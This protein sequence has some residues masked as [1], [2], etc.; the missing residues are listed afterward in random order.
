MNTD[1]P[2]DLTPEEKTILAIHL[3]RDPEVMQQVSGVLKPEDFDH[4]LE[5]G[6]RLIY[7]TAFE[8]WKKYGKP[9]ARPYLMSRI[10]EQVDDSVMFP[11]E[12]QKEEL[13]QFVDIIYRWPAGELA[14]DK[15][16]EL[17][18]KFVDER[19]LRRLAQADRPVPELIPKLLDA[20]SSSRIEGPADYTAHA[21]EQE[22]LRYII[23][24]AAR[25][26]GDKAFAELDRAGVTPGSF[27]CG[28]PM[29]VHTL[30]FAAVAELF[31]EGREF[32]PANILERIS[33]RHNAA[34]AEAL[35][36]VAVTVPVSRDTFAAH[37]GNLAK[38]GEEL[39]LRSALGRATESLDRGVT[40]DAV[41]TGL[42]EHLERPRGGRV[43]SQQERLE[44]Y[45][46]R[47]QERGHIIPVQ[48]F[49][50]RRA[51]ISTDP[52]HEYDP[53]IHNWGGLSEMLNG[54]LIPGEVLVVGGRS[55]VGKSS[56]VLQMADGVAADNVMREKEGKPPVPVL[57]VSLE[58]DGV[59]LYEMSLS[60]RSLVNGGRIHGRSY[61]DDRDEVVEVARARKWYEA[62]VA[63]YLRVMDPELLGY[64]G[65][66]IPEIRHQVR[67]LKLDFDRCPSALVVVEKTKCL[68]TGD[69]RLDRDD[70]SRV[71]KLAK[72][73]LVLAKRENVAVIMLSDST[74]AAVKNAE[75][76]GETGELGFRSSYTINH[77]GSTLLYLETGD[78]FEE[79]FPRIFDKDG[80]KLPKGTNRRKLSAL[81]RDLAKRI[82]D[83]NAFPLSNGA[84]FDYTKTYKSCY[85]AALCSKR[86]WQ[87]A[88]TPVFIYHRA[89]RLFE[90]IPA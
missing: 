15:A 61:L 45:D 70:T 75:G 76:R 11:L 32:T 83:L 64:E 72:Q 16:V 46:R 9:I 33:P 19:V 13:C 90:E 20:F 69:D 23:N 24:A 74:K 8:H 48:C 25:G 57:Y 63:P 53:R 56:F 67:R 79:L 2:N 59:E 87:L 81:Y 42:L 1:P 58:L 10:K 17:A 85:A 52:R 7:E 89:I 80:V 26:E 54:G 12:E 14:G 77:V 62:E 40:P 5:A 86:R 68:V 88:H 4:P 82:G 41:Q 34:A 37:L 31:R 66:T 55:G 65:L 38:Q 60:R 47:L 3:V 29:A 18:Q 73:L 39:A 51:P 43:P 49:R 6:L 22:V 21:Q 78:T 36:A 28:V 44:D 84:A 71:N 27:V 50:M 30:I 35:K